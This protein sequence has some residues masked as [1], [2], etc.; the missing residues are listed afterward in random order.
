LSEQCPF[1]TTL[2]EDGAQK[3]QGCLLAARGRGYG[4]NR[5]VHSEMNE[6]ARK[7]RRIEANGVERNNREHRGK[8]TKKARHALREFSYC[9]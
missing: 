3:M 5:V 9:V 6:A 1:P 2:Y 4:I 7:R 8:P